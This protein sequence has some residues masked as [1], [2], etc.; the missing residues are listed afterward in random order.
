MILHP[1]IPLYLSGPRSSSYVIS[2]Q[3]HTRDNQRWATSPNTKSTLAFHHCSITCCCLFFQSRILS[4]VMHGIW[5]CVS[6]D[7]APHD[8]KSE[9]SRPHVL[10]DGWK[11]RPPS[12]NLHPND[13]RGPVSSAFICKA[14]TPN[15]PPIRFYTSSM[16]PAGQAS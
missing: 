13:S 12:R 15:S 14:F 8:T 2:H 16:G 3:C 10:G 7:S 4:S 1:Q 11:S 9:Q 6:P 5:W